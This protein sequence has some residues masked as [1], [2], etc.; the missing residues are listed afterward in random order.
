[1]QIH[2][3]ANIQMP[4]YLGMQIGKYSRRAVVG[5]VNIQASGGEKSRGEGEEES[6]ESSHQRVRKS[7]PYVPNVRTVCS[8]SSHKRREHPMNINNLAKT[9]LNIRYSIIIKYR[10]PF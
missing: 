9:I 1:M 3:A 6:S 5:Y 4:T 10:E 2:K 7:S 8:G